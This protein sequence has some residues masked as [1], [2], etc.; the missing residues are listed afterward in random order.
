VDKRHADRTPA[1]S[2][3]M[4]RELHE[5]WRLCGAKV[6]GKPLVNGGNNLYDRIQHLF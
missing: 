5:Y 3:I 2:D 4:W 6:S 1:I